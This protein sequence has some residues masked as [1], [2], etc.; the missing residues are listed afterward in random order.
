[1]TTKDDVIRIHNQHPDWN[2][3]QI[4]KALDCSTGYVRSTATRQGLKLQKTRRYKKRSKQCLLREAARLIER[5]KTAPDEEQ[6]KKTL[7]YKKGAQDG[8]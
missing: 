1:M 5:A 7:T 4:A 6:T 3:T 2:D 8:R